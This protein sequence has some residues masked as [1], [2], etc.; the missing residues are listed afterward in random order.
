[1]SKPVTPAMP[2]EHTGMLNIEVVYALPT[3]QT[4]ITLVVPPGTTAI[5]AVR[6]S[7]ILEQHQMTASKELPLGIFGKK[8]SHD[9]P[10]KAM[11]RVEIYRPLIANAKEMRRQ[12]AT[13]LKTATAKRA[14]S[15]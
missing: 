9:R 14:N 10:L 8:V 13:K 6:Q 5:A 1:M 15:R 2:E 11:D 4:L 12:R 7:G 3:S